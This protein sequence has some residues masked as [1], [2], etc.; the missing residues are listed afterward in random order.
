M[1]SNHKRWRRKRN[2]GDLTLRAKVVVNGRNPRSFKDH[3]EQCIS[4]SDRSELY[5][6]RRSLPWPND[7]IVYMTRYSCN[8]NKLKKMLKP[9]ERSWKEYPVDSEQLSILWAFSDPWLCMSSSPCSGVCS[10]ISV[11]KATCPSRNQDPFLERMIS[12]S[13]RCQ[14]IRQERDRYGPLAFPSEAYAVQ[15]N[16]Q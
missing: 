9:L 2:E 8:D 12:L 3:Y 11:M 16:G 5:G 15:R 10:Y 13:N 4:E 7:H 14:A 6:R 1:I